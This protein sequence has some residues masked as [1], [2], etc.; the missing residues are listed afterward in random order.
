MLNPADDYVNERGNELHLPPPPC[1]FLNS[2][3]TAALTHTPAAV[4]G[5][6]LRQKAPSG[7]TIPDPQ[8][9]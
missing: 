8:K 2:K 3:A 7:A 1:C 4:V 9:L 6:T 5:E